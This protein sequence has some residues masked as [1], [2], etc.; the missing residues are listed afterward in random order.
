MGSCYL[1]FSE[2]DTWGVAEHRCQELN[3][4][5]VSITSQQEQN[6]VNCE[7]LLLCVVCCRLHVHYMC[8]TCNHVASISPLSS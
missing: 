2:R 8:V 6:F 3:S 1:H 5:L 4:H 7:Y